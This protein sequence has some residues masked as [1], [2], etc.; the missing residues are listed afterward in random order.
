MAVYVDTGLFVALVFEDDNQHKRAG[1]LID[2]LSRGEHGRP[3]FTSD[4]VFSETASVI[5]SRIKGSNKDYRALN[6]VR[7]IKDLI[8]ERRLEM[9]YLGE[10]SFREGFDL[11]IQHQ[12]RLDFV[13]STNLVLMKS[14]RICKIASFDSNYDAFA[15]EGIERV[16]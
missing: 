13:D 7:Q 16:H 8:Q 14:K 1:E 9:L 10:T 12:G 6:K 11:Y 5:H 2:E 15:G 4:L 3:L